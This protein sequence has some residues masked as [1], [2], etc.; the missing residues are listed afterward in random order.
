MTKN[1]CHAWQI[2]AV[3]GV[4]VGVWVNPLKKENLWQKCFSFSDNV[5][6]S[7]KNLWKMIS[8]AEEANKNNKK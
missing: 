8:A 4:G 1:F 3:K 2:L 6:W 5:E 7:S